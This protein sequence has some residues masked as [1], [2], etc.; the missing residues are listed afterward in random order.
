MN[1]RI[2]LNCFALAFASANVLAQQSITPS[3]GSASP[4]SGGQVALANKIYGHEVRGS[5][6][7][8]LGNL[9]N[10][11]VDL[12]SGRVLYAVIGSGKTRVAVPPEVFAGTEPSGNFLR[13]NVT[14][15][16]VDGAPQFG[17]PMDND[18]G[19]GS[20]AFVSQVYSYF[21]KNPWWQGTAPA[22]EGTFHNVHKASQL[23]GMK[24]QNVNNQ[25]IGKINNLA[26]NLPEGRVVAVLF[27][28][29]ASLGLNGN[30]YPM[31]PQAVTLSSDRK[32]LVSNID[33]SKLGSA[34]HFSGSNFPNFSDQS[35]IAQVYQYYGKQTWF[36]TPTAQPT[37]R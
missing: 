32:N 19:L 27:S 11:V 17:A 6:N 28:P 4:I 20:A 37:G 8:Q 24:V 13:V 23:L 22:N 34:P 16:K 3:A 30:V 1:A 31:P 14:K 10:L 29:D 18:T 26:V 9:N 36:G 33:A 2:V 5:D 12:E 35:Y 25:N 7:E 15:Q 21:G